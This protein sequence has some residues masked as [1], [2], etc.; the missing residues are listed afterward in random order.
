M[1]RSRRY[2]ALLLFAL[3]GAGGA[4]AP[5][6][7]ATWYLITADDGS[8]IGHSSQQITETADGR[9]T[10]S[11]QELLLQEEGDPVTHVTDSTVIRQDRDGRVVAITDDAATGRSTTRTVARITRDRAEITRTM[12]GEKREIS[13]A[14]PPGVRFDGGA[15]LLK[16]WDPATTPRL[17]FANFSIDAMAVERMSVELIPGAAPDPEGRIAVLRKRYDGT[18]LRAVARLTL[19][20]DR[21]IVS[22]TQPM[23]GTA[24]TTRATDRE[25]A[26]KPHPPYRVLAKVLLKAPFRISDGAA[27]GKIRYRFGF[28]DG[29]VFAPLETAEQR[30]T[31][32][33][34]QVT[35][36][37]CADCGPGM[38]ADEASL[39]DARRPAPW[40]Q[41]DHPRLEAVAGPIAKLHA[42]DARKMELL[43]ERARKTIERIEFAGHYSALE[44]LE[45][46]AGDCTEAAVLLAALGR[47][48]GI[49][50]RV[51]NGLVYSRPRY[52]GV[53][54]VFMPHS[55]VAAWVDGKW[56]SY[57]AAFEYFDSTH[58]ALTI[59]DGDA[60]SILAASQ[61]ASLLRWEEMTEVRARPEPAPSGTQ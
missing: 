33:P 59:G 24:I 1:V 21:G 45:R 46:R 40:L 14:L 47:A 18:A 39:A 2:A 29:I 15:G 32:A 41:S 55:W 38:P 44:A 5:D 56:K 11:R 20:R 4:D 52:H 36:D 42:T 53:A 13:V 51:V 43:A 25:T 54:N 50:T 9:E 61:L 57:D 35:L 48:A 8:V 22:V 3:L 7:P 28:R 49:P 27:L 60:R 6:P 12:R 31:L 10:L 34:D 37:I 17:D 26:L 30:V 16:L 23:F 58:I 19:S